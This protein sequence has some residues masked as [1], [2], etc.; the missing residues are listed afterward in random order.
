MGSKSSN[1]HYFSKCKDG[2]HGVPK[3]L[4]FEGHKEASVN[5][6]GL[7]GENM[8]PGASMGRTG[9]PGTTWL[10]VCEGIPGQKGAGSE[11]RVMLGAGLYVL[12]LGCPWVGA[13]RREF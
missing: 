3:C 8:A 7:S 11:G 13:A 9:K 2:M 5:T 12:L 10:H 1:K 4:V 6:G